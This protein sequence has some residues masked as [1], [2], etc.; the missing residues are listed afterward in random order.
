MIDISFEKNSELYRDYEKCLEFLSNIKEEDYE[1]PEEQ[2]NFHIYTEIK[3]EKELMV[4]KS[5][6]ATQN[7]EKCK[8]TVW[9]DY[10]IEDN[11]L[12]QPYKEHLNL[13]VW[14][15]VN[16]AIGTPLEGRYDLLLAKDHKH[17]LQSDLLRILVLNKYGGIWVD[18]DIIILRDFLPLMDQEYMYMWGS[19]TDFAT[20]GACA[21]VLSLQKN[22]EFSNK[23]I[24]Q[25]KI[26]PPIP[27][28]CCWGKDMFAPLYRKYQY[29]I[30]PSTFFNTEWCIN[31][32]YPGTG[33]STQIQK[34]WFKNAPK[35]E[36]DTRFGADN[37]YLF[38]EAF[39]WHWHNDSKKDMIPEP[40]SKFWLLTEFI[41]QKLIE[42]GFS[43]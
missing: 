7:L 1:Y 8:L 5:Y 14:D 6:L 25:L 15:P 13:K 36:N 16:E 39:T 42:K 3:T 37:N 38:L 40:G 27:A 17:Y 22:S 21:T 33:Y 30:L 11:P 29:P 9:S 34:S 19:E 32:K 26:T 43:L 18:M 20:M 41:N 4:I 10:S 31:V 24:E 2:V 23:L 12:I 28:T 35:P